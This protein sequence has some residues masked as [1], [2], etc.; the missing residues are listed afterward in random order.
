M[1]PEELTS[2]GKLASYY[3]EVLVPPTLQRL[4]KIY[5]RNRNHLKIDDII[6]YFALYKDL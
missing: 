4:V 5:R 1:V 6:F 2:V 3:S